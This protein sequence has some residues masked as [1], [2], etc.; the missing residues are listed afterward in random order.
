MVKRQSSDDI[1]KQSLK[2]QLQTYLDF[3]KQELNAAID[4]AIEQNIVEPSIKQQFN[5]L[6]ILH[7]AWQ[8]VDVVNPNFDSKV[9]QAIQDELTLCDKYASETFDKLDACVNALI[10]LYKLTQSKQN[11]HDELA[12]FIVKIC[13]ATCQ[14]P[15]NVNSEHLSDKYSVV[16][17][18]NRI[19][20]N[21]FGVHT[22]EFKFDD[23]V[24]FCAKI[25]N[26][27]GKNIALT[28]DNK[29]GSFDFRQS[30]FKSMSFAYAIINALLNNKSF[31]SI[32]NQWFIETRRID[33]SRW[34]LKQVFRAIIG[35][36]N[37]VIAQKVCNGHCFEAIY[38]CQSGSSTIQE[39]MY[40]N[41]S[42]DI[43]IGRLK[44]RLQGRRNYDA[45]VEWMMC[46]EYTT[47]S[48]DNTWLAYL[49]IKRSMQ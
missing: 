15:A 12:K 33:E 27:S 44:H 28:Y 39:I 17:A 40:N 1:Y 16:V 25:E 38:D 11:L 10:E 31:E 9:E 5:C 35:M 30:D 49:N 3:K 18:D 8:P 34:K 13:K 41:A 29:N 23:R 2:Q 32:V 42:K 22:V 7:A 45:L 46:C 48:I 43:E 24:H 14:A 19:W 20:V 21:F 36:Y 6:G 4:I 26:K 37:H 47:Q